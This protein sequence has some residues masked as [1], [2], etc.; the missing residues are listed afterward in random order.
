MTAKKL[1]ILAIDD[2]A[3]DAELLR[4]NL[5]QAYGLEIEFVHST[6]PDQAI[7]R[8][9]GQDVDVTF[10]DYELGARTGLEVL[11]RIRS[12]GDMRPLVVL[13]GRGDEYAAAKLAREGA[14]EYIAKRDLNPD[15]L[16]RAID[17]ARR[18][19]RQRKTAADFAQQQARLTELIIE[20]N[21]ELE[22]A[23]RLDPLTKLLNRTAFSEAA[24]L[25]HER[26]SRYR[27]VY[28]I[29]MIDVDHFKQLND[30]RGH[31]TGDKCL[32][33]ISRCLLQT[34]RALDSVGRYGGEE[35]V[36]LAPETD[37]SG[38]C[39]LAE[40]IRRSIWHL[41]L[42]HPA[43]TAADRVTVSIGVASALAGQWDDV[44]RRA[45]DSLYL[46]KR[47]GRN[48]VCSEPPTPQQS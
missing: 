19:Y 44:L 40:Q 48:R 43:S 33:E 2:D 29:L 13:T 9:S 11:Q 1:K 4:R 37:V 7:E 10:L 32:Q 28:S 45:D 24:T 31:Q 34:C 23:N 26:S 27:H 42:A 22:Q 5:E 3:G 20:A 38:A 46:A 16:Q 47:R 36:V 8:L 18:R 12:S 14:D 15:V 41:N 35:F 25:E 30:S 21:I 39:A 17:T 6:E